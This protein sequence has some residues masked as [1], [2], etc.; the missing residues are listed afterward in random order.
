MAAG[1]PGT[2]GNAQWGFK[3]STTSVV[4]L[5][6]ASIGALK[7][8]ITLSLP[9]QYAFGQ[10][11]QGVVE[12]SHVCIKR[13]LTI[14]FGGEEILLA[15]L[16]YALDNDAAVGTV[17]TIDDDVGST[18]ALVVNTWPPNNAGSDTRVISMPTALGI[19]D[20]GFVLTDARG[21]A[22]SSM[23]YTF[24]AIASSVQLLGTLTD[25]YA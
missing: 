17:L 24:K 22:F 18:V 23:A 5:A 25:T 19:G 6:A 20:G 4:T 3:P 2:Q 16:Q 11:D 15:N 9:R 21:G 8:D 7:G 1:S 10:L 12:F 14:S 13:E